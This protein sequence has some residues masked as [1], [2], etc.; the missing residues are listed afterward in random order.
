MAFCA[1][2]LKSLESHTLGSAVNARLKTRN[3]AAAEECDGSSSIAN[4][5]MR[6]STS[7]ALQELNEK[8]IFFFVGPSPR[9]DIWPG[10]LKIETW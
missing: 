7:T 1:D 9:K 4:W 2:R 8:R 5:K 3:N 6:P 10:D